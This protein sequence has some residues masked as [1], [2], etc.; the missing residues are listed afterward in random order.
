MKT[1]IR[2]AMSALFLILFAGC[3]EP[4]APVVPDEPVVKEPRPILIPVAETVKAPE[5]AVPMADIDKA[6]GL[7][8]VLNDAVL[9]DEQKQEKAAALMAENGWTEESYQALLYDISQD[10]PSRAAYVGLTGAK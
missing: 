3:S 7:Y 5:P 10:A 2:I 8:K 9:A 4:A 6:A 1:I